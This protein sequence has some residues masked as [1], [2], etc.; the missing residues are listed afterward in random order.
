MEGYGFSYF[1]A[2]SILPSNRDIPLDC[3]PS[4][5]HDT[6]ASVFGTPADLKRP[7]ARVLEEYSTQ[8]I[9]PKIGGRFSRNFRRFVSDIEARP[10]QYKELEEASRKHPD[11]LSSVQFCARRMGQLIDEGAQLAAVCPQVIWPEKSSHISTRFRVLV[12][13]TNRKEYRERPAIYVLIKEW[14][15]VIK[16][17]PKEEQYSRLQEI[18]AKGNGW[19]G[20]AVTLGCYSGFSYEKLL[21]LTSGNGARKHLE[22]LYPRDGV[23]STYKGVFE[24]ADAFTAAFPSHL[25]SLKVKYEVPVVYGVDMGS[26]VHDVV[27][28]ILDKGL[29]L[30][31]A[32]A[33]D[34]LERYGFL[35]FYRPLDVFLAELDRVDREHNMFEAKLLTS[36]VIYRIQNFVRGHE[37][38]EPRFDITGVGMVPVVA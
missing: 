8:V 21:E 26:V 24:M 35:M 37:V 16:K 25:L 4:L 29:A 38:L 3:P 15:Q 9:A 28:G 2:L 30:S 19:E 36:E 33:Q 1:R 20:L 23:D 7:I 12:N 13:E 22:S 10:E 14:H 18:A 32:D 5:L 11:V 34:I 17:M 31:P 27:K 6:C